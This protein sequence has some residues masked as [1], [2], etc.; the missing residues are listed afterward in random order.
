MRVAVAV[1]P[2]AL[3]DF[4]SDFEKAAVREDATRAFVPD[5]HMRLN[6]RQARRVAP[7]VHRKLDDTESRLGRV[8]FAPLCAGDPIP[9]R[10]RRPILGVTQADT[11][12]K[13]V[14]R[15][16]RNHKV[17]DT[18]IRSPLTNDACKRDRVF[19]SVGMWNGAKPTGH[20][21]IA[22]SR[23]KRRE[24]CFQERPQRETRGRKRWCNSAT[25][26]HVK[27]LYTV[28]L[29]CMP[30]Q[31]SHAGPLDANSFRQHGYALIDWI[32]DYRESM[33]ERSVQHSTTPGAIREHL[34]AR[35]PEAGE[36]FECILRD[37]DTIVMPGIAHWQHPGW[38]AYFPANSSYESI[39]GELASAGLGVQGMLWSTSPACTELETHVLDWLV[40][41]LGLP[42]QFLSS[43][44]GGGVLQD[45]ASSAALV[46]LVAARERAT[47]FA[48]D[49]FGLKVIDQRLTAY[50]SSQ[51]HSSVE[52]ATRIAG[53]GKE[54]L[55]VIP[56]DATGAMRIDLL[57]TCMS[58]DRA[59]GFHCA[60]VNASVGTT[61]VNAFDD[62][63]AIR[64]VCRAHEG[65]RPIWLHVDAAMSG[66]AALCPE[67][68]FVVD[69]AECADS[70]CFNPHKW[71]PVNFDCDAMF[72]AQRG[73]LVRA[74]S[75][76][77]EYLRNAAT[78]SGKVIDYRDWQIP[79]GRRF[80]ALKL[81]F[82][83]RS[84][85]LN[86]LRAMV[87][88]HVRLGQELAARVRA[89]D[90]LHL[91]VE[92]RLNLV[93]I[94]HND[95]DAATEALLERVN[96]SG[97]S[98]VSHCRFTADGAQTPGKFVLRVSLGSLSTKREHL[99]LLWRA[100]SLR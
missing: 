73:E 2:T 40:H 83:L 15:H 80:R 47:N 87:R 7:P 70:W 84:W 81:W 98:F 21:T 100:L 43:G 91:V 36:R 5:M 34:S 35:A 16:G 75:V 48:S 39:L 26:F 86:G 37:L 76:L 78:D 62:V 96:A 38:F 65:A 63:R 89:S 93:A 56:V 1:E 90:H 97:H 24:V 31:E 92:P 13:R 9:K 88:E 4:H 85:G 60:F 57:N 18:A 11:A 17:V 58:A 50:T 72:V 64:E 46:A 29:P 10:S 74:L 79:L 66:T 68:R 67:F 20:L 32:A 99:D 23:D 54:S 44:T 22:K 69:G 28:T 59:A 94:T 52:K 77:P 45:T 95:G 12:H 8:T 55:R 14:V 53:L 41:A 25:I 71:M 42:E 82:V 61:G 27:L 33:S 49:A 6:L 19:D 30:Q 51:A 3:D